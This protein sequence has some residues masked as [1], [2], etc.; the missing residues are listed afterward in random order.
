MKHVF[1]A[2]CL[3]TALLV[4]TQNN[5]QRFETV[6]SVP[7][8]NI[9]YA[10]AA[11]SS[12][13]YAGTGG[14]GLFRSFDDGITWSSCNNGTPA[15]YFFS[16]LAKHDTLYAGSFG[17]VYFSADK[18]NSWTGAGL[19]LNVNDNV[20]SLAKNGQYVFA[21]IK[22][23]GV[24]RAI[25]GSGSWSA[26]SS[27]LHPAATIYDL[28]YSNGVLFAASDLGLYRSADNANSWQGVNGFPGVKVNQLFSYN[29]II[30][31]ATAAGIYRS[32]NA[33]VSWTN[34]SAGIPS[35]TEMLCLTGLDNVM[36]AGASTNSAS[37][38]FLSSDTGLS[39]TPYTASGAACCP[40]NELVTFHNFV[41]S[42]NSGV[43]TRYSEAPLA[44]DASSYDFFQIYPN[45]FSNSMV[46]E[47]PD[48]TQGVYKIYGFDSKELL[49]GKL[50]DGK[51]ELDLH[52]LSPG[53]YLFRLESAGKIYIKKIVKN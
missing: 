30:F 36:F 40:F 5:A 38:A 3:I 19:N 45:P 8:N 33:G 39:W 21:G 35:N 1:T 24:Y 13:V 31:A 12:Y 11:N 34:A 29:N 26:K 2:A 43:I 52:S 42:G 10:L 6:F 9:V 47:M 20:L 18:G 50:N 37:G 51:T 7:G 4:P 32:Q 27:G 23:N 15:G 22:Q 46:V 17:T 53:I 44:V 41:F 48:L 49:S 28:L 25:L 16:L 14:S